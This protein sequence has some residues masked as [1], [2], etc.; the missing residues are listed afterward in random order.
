MIQSFTTHIFILCGRQCRRDGVFAYIMCV[1]HC[2][3]FLLCR[4][5]E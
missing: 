1:I 5:I 2:F 3:F 4:V